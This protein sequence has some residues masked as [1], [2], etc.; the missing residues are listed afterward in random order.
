MMVSI[1]SLWIPILLSAVIVFLASSFIHMV[2]RYHRTDFGKVPSEDKVMDALREFDIPPGEYVIPFAGSA[3]EMGTPE[4]IEKTTK[5]PVAFMTVLPSG[6]PSMAKSLVQ[7]FIYCVIVGIIAAYITGRALEPGAEY[8]TIFRF[9][10]CTAFVGYAVALWQNSIWYKRSWSTTF[11]STFDGLVYALL[12][13][14]TF[15]WLWPA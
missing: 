2:L 10:G 6:R 13:A 14:G 7:W 4:F 15:G 1:I 5:G 11:K 8:L 9:A 3:K 12:T